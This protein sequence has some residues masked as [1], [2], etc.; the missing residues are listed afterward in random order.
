MLRRRQI[1][2]YP[3]SIWI[4]LANALEL[5]G[6]TYEAMEVLEELLRK[7]PENDTAHF[8]LGNIMMKLGRLASAEYHFS[9]AIRLGFPAAAYNLNQVKQE[10]QRRS[11]ENY[12]YLR[13]PGFQS[14]KN[15][16]R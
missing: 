11:Q 5:N 1:Q 15:P 2:L 6:N 4:N 13:R 14:R 12:M 16:R 3:S 8:N 10:R 9:E 7:Y